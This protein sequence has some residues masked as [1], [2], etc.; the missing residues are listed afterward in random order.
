MA[1]KEMVQLWKDNRHCAV[2]L[3]K[4]WA[5]VKITLL[6]HQEATCYIYAFH[7]Y[8]ELVVWC[9]RSPLL[10]GPEWISKVNKK[11]WEELIAY[12]PLILHRPH[13]KWRLQQFFIAAGTVFTEPLP[14]NDKGID[15]KPHKYKQIL[16][17]RITI[18][19]LC[20]TKRLSTP[21]WDIRWHTPHWHIK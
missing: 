9:L 16:M 5:S 15:R 10:I 1:N 17:Y 2:G 4:K 3:R 11:L 18:L 20:N 19:K 14:N 13:R 12:F 6:G 8:G 21:H 7:P